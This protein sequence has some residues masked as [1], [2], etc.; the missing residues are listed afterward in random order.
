MRIAE[1]EES[2]GLLEG[3]TTHPRTIPMILE[4]ILYFEVEW[5]L[6]LLE[7]LHVDIS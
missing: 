3:Q 6:G 5:A 7:S 4:Q 2:L 1:A